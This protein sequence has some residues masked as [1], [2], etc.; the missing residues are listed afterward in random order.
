[1]NGRRRV[2]LCSTNAREER[3]GDDDG[4]ET[5]MA[6]MMGGRGMG[7]GSCRMRR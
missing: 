2:F 3:V 4:Y 1:M 7:N 6:E 5:A